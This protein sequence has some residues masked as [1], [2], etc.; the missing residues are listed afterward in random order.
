[1]NAVQQDDPPQSAR[2]TETEVRHVL[3]RATSLQ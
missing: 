2:A 1:M 3:T